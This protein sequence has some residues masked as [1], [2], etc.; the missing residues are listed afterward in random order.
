L[1]ALKSAVESKRQHARPGSGTAI[2]SA[3]CLARMAYTFGDLGRFDDARDHFAQALQ[4]LGDVEHSLRASILEL[5]CAVHLW[6]GRWAE[7]REAGFD[8]ADVAWRCRSRY[9]T[10][11]GRALG[12]CAVWAIDR[13][14]PAHQAL[15][16]AAYLIDSRGGAVSTSLLFGWLLESATTLGLHGELRLHTA[17]LM[18]RSR[19]QDRHGHAM[20]C[21]ALAAHAG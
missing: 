4:M 12:G 14:L 19:C 7:A 1:P 11:M 6:Q 9:L 20:G 18:Q 16:D 17:K 3:Y 2:G 8:G 10:T 13:D 5:I 15:R 21:R